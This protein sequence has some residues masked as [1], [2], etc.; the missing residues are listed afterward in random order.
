MNLNDVICYTC[1]ICLCDAVIRL[2][3]WRNMEQ[4]Q[5]MEGGAA[6]TETPFSLQQHAEPSTC[7]EAVI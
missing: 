7:F 2:S 3:H 6:E 1:Y 4:N 5:V